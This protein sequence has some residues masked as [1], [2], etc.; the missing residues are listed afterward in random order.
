VGPLALLLTDPAVTGRT[1]LL[2]GTLTPEGL[3][4]AAA[5]LRSANN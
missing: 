4:M 5:D 1:M 3:S 2:A